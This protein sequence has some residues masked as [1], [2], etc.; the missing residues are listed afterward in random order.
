MEQFKKSLRFYFL[1]RNPTPEHRIAI[2]DANNTLSK[3]LSR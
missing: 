2:L 1:M 3:P